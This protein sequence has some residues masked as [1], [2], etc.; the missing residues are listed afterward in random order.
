MV[1]PL[2]MG[3]QEGGVCFGNS[4]SGDPFVQTSKD[5]LLHPSFT[6]EEL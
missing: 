6:T 5:D 1:P 4:A 3:V 2:F